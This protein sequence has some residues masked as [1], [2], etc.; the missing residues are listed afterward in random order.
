MKPKQIVR[1]KEAPRRL[2]CGKTKFENDHVLHDPNDPFV[3]GTEIPRL[4]PVALG[5]R[6]VGFIEDELEGLIDGLRAARDAALA[7]AVT[8]EHLAATQAMERER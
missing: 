8:G 2:G 5:P 7:P 4:K 6:N 3:P 1:K